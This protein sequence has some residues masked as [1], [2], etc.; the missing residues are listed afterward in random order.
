MLMPT[1]Q[2]VLGFDWCRTYDRCSLSAV[3]ISVA[4]EFNNLAELQQIFKVTKA[5]TPPSADSAPLFRDVSSV[6]MY[7]ANVRVGVDY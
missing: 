7:G 5:P 3:R 4:G 6:Y 2:I 1:T